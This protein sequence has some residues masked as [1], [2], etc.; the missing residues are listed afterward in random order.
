LT[1]KIDHSSPNFAGGVKKCKMG[2]APNFSG[3]SGAEFAAS[4]LA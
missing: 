3:G 4:W 2:A 1:E